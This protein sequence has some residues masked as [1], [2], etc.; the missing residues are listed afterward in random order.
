MGD[1]S[2]FFA[3]GGTG[4]H[5]YP[6]LAVAEQIVAQRPDAHV[7]F[8]CSTRAIDKRILDTTSFA[9]TTLPATGLYFDP[10]RLLRFLATFHRSYRQARALLSGSPKGS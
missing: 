4:G 9:Y 1:V 5:I 7:H 6:A 2:F 10:K 3:G 8:L